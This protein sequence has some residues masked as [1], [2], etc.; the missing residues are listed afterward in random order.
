MQTFPVYFP[1]RHCKF[2]WI[3][4]TKGLVC[5]SNKCGCKYFTHLSNQRCKYKLKLSHHYLYH[6]HHRYRYNTRSKMMCLDIKIWWSSSARVNSNALVNLSVNLVAT[7]DQ[8]L[9]LF[10]WKI[11]SFGVKY[12]FT[13][14]K[15]IN[16]NS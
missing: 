8:T 12:Q 13:I 15:K 10:L 3:F 16:Y 9:K 11:I 7:R 1:H 2:I 14:Q 5:L 4:Y 6:H